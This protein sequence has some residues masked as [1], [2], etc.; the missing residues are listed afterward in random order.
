MNFD[1]KNENVVIYI[2][3]EITLKNWGITLTK[4]NFNGPIRQEYRKLGAVISNGSI[5]YDYPANGGDLGVHIE[6]KNKEKYDYSCPQ[7]Y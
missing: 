6:G 5:K 7:Q 1:P 4:Q 3:D 2:S